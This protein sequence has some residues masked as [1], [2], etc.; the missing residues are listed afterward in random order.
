MKQP[1]LPAPDHGAPRARSLPVAAADEEPPSRAASISVSVAN[2]QTA[3]E[4]C[5]ETLAAAV[6][7]VLRGE[8]RG[9]AEISLAVVDNAEIHRLNRQFLQHDY[10]TDALSFV[11]A[12]D[13]ACLEGEIVVSAEMAM[14]QAPRYHWQAEHELLLYVVHAA[15]HLSGYDDGEPE[16][17]QQMR[18]RERH[19]LAALG[20]AARGLDDDSPGIGSTVAAAAVGEIPA[21]PRTND[22]SD[23]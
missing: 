21:V 18:D 5:E 17:Q 6:R 13:D 2:R 10:P 22:G 8:G 20:V 23:S 19:H 16:A 15:L 12:D 1:S 11:L 9:R 7:Q 3:L 14:Q 4:V